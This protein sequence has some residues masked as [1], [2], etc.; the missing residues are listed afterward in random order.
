MSF[1]R[2][3]HS[4][5]Y[6][7]CKIKSERKTASESDDLPLT[8]EVSTTCVV[9]LHSS[10][11]KSPTQSKHT[12]VCV[13]SRNIYFKLHLFT[14]S[15]TWIYLLKCTCRWI[16]FCF[17]RILHGKCEAYHVVC[18]SCTSL[19]TWNLMII[20]ARARVTRALTLEHTGL[21]LLVFSLRC[22]THMSLD[23]AKLCTINALPPFFNFK[24]DIIKHNCHPCCYWQETH[25][26]SH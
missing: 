20:A 9:S 1:C 10:S 5:S 25:I 12:I 15:L 17:W 8:Q 21:D 7:K 24:T 14:Y 19:L 23:Y 22:V 2:M 26:K 6:W 4:E 13:D 16:K 11:H 3:F 18:F